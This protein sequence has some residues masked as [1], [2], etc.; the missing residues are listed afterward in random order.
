MAT[1]GHLYTTPGVWKPW[2]DGITDGFL[3]RYDPN[4]NLLACTSMGVPVGAVALAS[5]GGVIAGG[6]LLTG[7]GGS[8]VCYPFYIGSYYTRSM[9]QGPFST[10]WFG[11]VASDFSQLQF[12]SFVGG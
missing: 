7:S 10:S 2:A 6:Q 9:L 8:S 1:G 11:R 3:A 5:D 12:S 4:G